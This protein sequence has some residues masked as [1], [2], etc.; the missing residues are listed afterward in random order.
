MEE[1]KHMDDADR[2]MEIPISY[3]ER[4]KEKGKEIGREEGIRQVAMEML[5]KGAAVN[6][7]SEVTKLSKKEIE[8]LKREL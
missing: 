3:E 2:I 4:G 8:A 7:I 1:I 5:R 6:F